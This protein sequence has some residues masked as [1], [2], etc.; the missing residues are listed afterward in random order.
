MSTTTSARARRRRALLCMALGAGAC[1]HRSPTPSSAPPPADDEAAFARALETL[2]TRDVPVR[3]AEVPAPHRGSLLRAGVSAEGLAGRPTLR[4]EQAGSTTG[5]HSM[6]VDADA[7]YAG[8]KTGALLAMTRAEGATRWEFSEPRPDRARPD[9]ACTRTRGPPRGFNVPPAFWRSTLLAVGHSGTLYMLDRETGALLWYF[10]EY[11]AR[12]LTPAIVDDVAYVAVDDRVLALDLITREPRWSASSPE[13]FTWP[14]PALQG[15][16]LYIGDFEGAL[17]A[18][19]TDDGVA[20]WRFPTEGFVTAGPALAGELAYFA[21]SKGTLLAVDAR[22]GAERWRQP[23]SAEPLMGL[24]VDDA[25]VYAIA[26]RD[27]TVV[28][29]DRETGAPRWSTKIAARAVHSQTLAGDT[30]LVG[31]SE[32]YL[33]ALDRERG[34]L[35][36]SYQAPGPILAAPIVDAGQVYIGTDYGRVLALE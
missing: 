34:A 28:A 11:D 29:V 14:G 9:G 2:V 3:D 36:W 24:V 22:W 19:A 33:R 31:D 27:A 8:T 21:N 25:R 7:V 4:W 12:L 30:L 13:F 26:V 15:G 1:S 23:L 18:F 20:Q 17:T 5:I 10:H 32:G 6:A 16:V 35:R